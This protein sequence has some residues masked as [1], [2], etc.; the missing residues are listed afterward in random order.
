MDNITKSI[1]VIGSGV[2]GLST[3]FLIKELCKKRDTPISITI[4]ESATRHGGATRTD[5]IDGYICEHGPNGFLDNEPLTLELVRLLGIES[6]LVKANENSAKRYIYHGN[7]LRKV[8]TKPLAFLLSSILPLSSKLR[9]AM[10][11]FVPAKKDDED[12]TIYSF[13][14][15]RLGKRFA[16]YLLDPMVSGIFAGNINEMSIA[17]AF[18]KIVNM[19]KRFGGLFKAMLKMR[20]NRNNNK[21]S[22][23]PSGPNAVL[24]TFRQGMGFLTDSL[25]DELSK[26][27]ITGVCV[28]A[29]SWEDG[30]F[31][32]VSKNHMWKAD[33]V[34]VACPSYEAAKILKIMDPLTAA[35]IDEI[36]YAPVDVICHGHNRDDIT[37]KLDGFGVLIPRLEKIRSLGSLWCDCIF[38]NQAPTGYRLLRT[39]LGG[40]HDRECVQLTEEQLSSI[41]YNDHKKIM[42]VT[43]EPLFQRVYRHTRG[44]AQYT[45]GHLDRVRKADIMENQLPGFYLTGAS[46]RG[47]SVNASIKDAFRIAHSL[48]EHMSNHQ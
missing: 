6:E 47:V 26:N 40:A 24:H 34:V 2:A 11:L 3:A 39:L 1:I 4:L 27:L 35:A 17:A 45:V 12:E 22:G 25:H 36:S 7:K 46:Y 8:P 28:E 41:V 32:V 44:I 31:K 43:K 16:D 33:G 30:K 10:E 15:R 38:P 20:T 37:N 23:G 13:G 21:A 9:M 29:V 5:V 18:P 14:K 42:G 48:C 19:E